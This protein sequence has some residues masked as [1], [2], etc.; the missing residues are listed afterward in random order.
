MMCSENLPTHENGI[1]FD[2]RNIMF[3]GKWN[4]FPRLFSLTNDGFQLYVKTF[5]K[6]YFCKT[7]KLSDG[8][9]NYII[10]EKESK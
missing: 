1:S 2:W 9:S 7:F 6:S 10:K 4:F 5:P 3:N 8:F